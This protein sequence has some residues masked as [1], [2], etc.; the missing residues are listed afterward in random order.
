MPDNGGASGPTARKITFPAGRSPPTIS[1][2]LLPP[3]RCPTFA[4]YFRL[5]RYGFRRHATYRAAAV[6]GAFTNTVFGV[7]RAYVLIALWQARPG[8]AGYDVADAVTFCFLTQ[9]FIGPMQVF[10]GGLELSQR[11]RTGDVA[12]DLIR[13]ASLQLWTL[14][15][16]LGRATWLFV[17]RSVPPTLAGAALFGIVT[18]SGPLAWAAF[19]ASVVLGVIVSFALRY[20]VALSACWVLDDRGVQSLSLV[21]T[22]FFSGMILPL[23]IFPGWLGA[24]A[25]ALPWAAIVQVPA[26]VYLGKADVAAALGFQALWAAALLALGALA[27]RAARRKV[28][29]QGG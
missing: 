25:Q 15:E 2:L 5:F 29:I 13:P 23:V 12:I 1:W 7:L 9:A 21:M 3:W 17:V 24:L 16:D 11:V 8:L 4:L 22:L 6:A 26:D 27:T 19:G 28:I 10:G 18:P 20:L 14:A